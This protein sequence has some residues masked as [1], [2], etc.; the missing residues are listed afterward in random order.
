MLWR[1]SLHEPRAAYLLYRGRKLM[2]S[3]NKLT[4]LCAVTFPNIPSER[5]LPSDFGSVSDPYAET[6]AGTNST[7]HGGRNLF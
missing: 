4:V 3:P 1:S 7:L 2:R 6:L 5:L